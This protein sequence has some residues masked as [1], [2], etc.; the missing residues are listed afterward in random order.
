MLASKE[1]ALHVAISNIGPTL[2]CYSGKSLD[3]QLAT[4]SDMKDWQNRLL[5]ELM[6]V[7]RLVFPSLSKLGA[8]KSAVILFFFTNKSG[9]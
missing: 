4:D 9:H 7:Y 1:K 8:A 2:H 6:C 3:L 5:I